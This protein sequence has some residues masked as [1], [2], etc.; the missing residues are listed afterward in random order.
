[1]EKAY[2]GASVFLLLCVTSQTIFI[3]DVVTSL[4]LCLSELT[5]RILRPNFVVDYG[6]SSQ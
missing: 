6:P 3:E 5:M 2:K 1:M 4:T